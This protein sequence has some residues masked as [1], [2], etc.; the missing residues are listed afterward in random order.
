M[1]GDAVG[2]TAEEFWRDEF[3]PQQP[4]PHAARGPGDLRA[5]RRRARRPGRTGAGTLDDAHGPA[6]LPGRPRRQRR[7]AAA[8]VRVQ[9]RDD[10][11]YG[12]SHYFAI[13]YSGGGRDQF[14][15]F[16]KACHQ[17]GIAVI[18]DVVY[19]HFTADAERAEWVYDTDAPESNIYYWYEGRRPTTPIPDGRLRRQRVDRLGAALLRRWSA[20]CSSAARRR[21][22]RSSTSTASASTRRRRS[23]LQRPA[24]RRPAACG[25]AN[26]FGRQVPARMDADAAA[27]Q[28]RT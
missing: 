10:W 9:R 6:R 21:W 25:N 15:H 11:G 14:K 18:L 3:G 1:A 7:R 13:E 2:M 16:I 28:A 24:R 20:S 27:D 8:D 17:R 4:V 19:N 22:S 5:A 23:I 26:I 12:T